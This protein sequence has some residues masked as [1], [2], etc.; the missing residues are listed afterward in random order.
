MKKGPVTLFYPLKRWV[1]HVNST[2][3]FGSRELTHHPK[4]VTLAELP[5]SLNLLAGIFQSTSGSTWYSKIAQY[6]NDFMV[7]SYIWAMRKGPLVV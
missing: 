5:G 2:F 4:K 6:V 7:T 1:R 3:D